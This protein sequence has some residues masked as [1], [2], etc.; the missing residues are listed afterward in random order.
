MKP[1][2]APRLKSLVLQPKGL[3]LIEF[4]LTCMHARVVDAQRAFRAG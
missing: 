3:Q 2:Q 4:I 1:G